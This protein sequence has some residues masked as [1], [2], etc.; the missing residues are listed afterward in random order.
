MSHN[1][2]RLGAAGGDQEVASVVD[3]AETRAALRRRP[4]SRRDVPQVSGGDVS[5][6]ELANSDTADEQG[7][8]IETVPTAVRLARALDALNRLA[9]ADE[10]PEGAS[11]G[12]RAEAYLA[13]ERARR[14]VCV[15]EARRLVA[16]A[17][18]SMVRNEDQDALGLDALGLV[19]QGPALPDGAG[20][21]VLERTFKEFD[22][23]RQDCRALRG[24]QRSRRG[25]G[26]VDRY[27]VAEHAVLNLSDGRPEVL[28]RQ[29]AL[30]L[31]LSDEISD[32]LGSATANAVTNIA[33]GLVLRL[34][35]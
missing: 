2:N 5:D 23:A 21:P 10:R 11:A 22:A 30:L 12:G 31:D 9:L 32:Q 1:D 29:A 24:P 26:S 33:Q 15:H 3:F 17:L 13:A 6:V 7:D 27:R 34:K 16:L 25:R 8:P 19:V 18:S 28:R 14:E 35:G 4:E 20:D